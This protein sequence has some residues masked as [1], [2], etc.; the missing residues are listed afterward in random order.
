MYD[1]NKY[2]VSSVNISSQKILRIYYDLCL[3]VAG[4]VFLVD[5]GF[6]ILLY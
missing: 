1:S 2:D 4:N 5:L 6:S 3:K